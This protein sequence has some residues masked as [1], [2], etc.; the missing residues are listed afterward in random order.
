MAA[1][2][3]QG[4]TKAKG[5]ENTRKLLRCGRECRSIAGRSRKEISFICD[6][7]QNLRNRGKWSPDGSCLSSLQF[8][9]IHPFADGNGRV[10]RTLMNYYL[11]L[12][13]LPPA[14]IYEEDKETYYLALAVFDKTEKLDGFVEYL[15]R[16]NCKNL[17]SWT[18][19][20]YRGK[21]RLL[22]CEVWW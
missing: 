20:P 10:G 8:E 5:R 13:D 11:M 18:P 6:E 17:D 2:M 19:V 4:G 3:K 1:M 9:N 22:K 14:V 21:K 15:E 16:R 12:H 7:G